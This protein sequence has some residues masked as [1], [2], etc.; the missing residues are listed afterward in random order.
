MVG[1][2]ISML[3]SGK[4]FGFVAIVGALG[5]MGMMIKNGIVLMDEIALRISQGVEPVAALLDSTSARF[6]PVMMA[7]MTTIFGM[8]PLITDD[9]F[10]AAAVTIMGGLM[11]GTLIT[12]LIVPVLYALFFKIKVV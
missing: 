11:F 8:L 2:I 12:L 5:L 3:L 9:L 10:G 7:S 1:V 4:T 6:R